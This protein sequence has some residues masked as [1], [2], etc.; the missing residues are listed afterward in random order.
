MTSACRIRVL[1]PLLVNKI[2]AG[3]VVERP[4]SVVKELIENALDAGAGRIAIEIEDGGRS[5]MRVTDDGAGMSGDELALAV[6]PHATSKIT[7]EDD[8]Y[9][10]ATMGFRGEALASI[11]SVSKLRIVARADGSD[12]G[13]EIRVVAERVEPVQAVGCPCGTSVEVRDLFFNVPA[14]RRFLRG[15][16]TEV[17]HINEQVARAALARPDIGFELKNN[18]RVTQGL[19]PTTTRLERISKFYGADLASALLRVERDERGIGLEI[20]VAP[21]VQSRATTQWQYTYVNGRF[22]RD[23]FIQHAIREAY[24]GLMEPSR[25]GV[26]FLFLTIDPSKVDVNVHPTKLEVRWAESNLIHSLTLST[27]RETF[28]RC[29]LTPRLRTDTG[30][31]LPQSTDPAVQ[32]QLRNDLADALKSVPPLRPGTYEGQ[33]VTAPQ[34]PPESAPPE[35]R[36]AGGASSRA[37]GPSAETPRARVDAEEIWRSLYGGAR[38]VEPPD[39]SSPM[40]ADAARMAARRP[41]A[42]QLHNLYLVMETDDGIVIVDQHAL[43][44][45]IIYEELCARLTK[46][47]LESQ[48]LLLPETINVTASQVALL[49]AGGGLLQR[50]GI[51]VTRFGADAVAVHSFPALLR[52]TD[53]VSVMRDLIDTLSEK[54]ATTDTERVIHK[55]LDMMACKAAVKAGDVLNEEEIEAMMARRNSVAKSSSCPHG[56]PTMLHLT[57]ADLDR[58]FKRT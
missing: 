22:V 58:Q 15:N 33:S 18:G 49:E 5:L 13:H 35:S 3:E 55:V 44:E 29:D 56:R 42:I 47:A 10:I 48:R 45:R 46:G 12:E 31:G 50:L 28:Q 52:D 14:R 41:K 38:A 11:S 7:S 57:K 30:R 51:E 36:Y 4:A 26:V 21:P 32:E 2:A 9:S 53:V 16:S 23:R 8:L 25:H 34:W 17:G 19:P 1:P 39:G 43:H 6:M 37:A 40:A 24:R 54:G 27:L 20:Y